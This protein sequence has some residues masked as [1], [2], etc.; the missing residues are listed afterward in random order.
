MFNNFVVTGQY[1]WTP[2]SKTLFDVN[3]MNQDTQ[4]VN[5]DGEENLEEGS[6][7]SVEDIISNYADDVC[8][9][10]TRVNMGNNST[11]NSNG[12]RKAREQYGG[13]S[14]KKNKKPYGFG[15]QLL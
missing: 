3:A 9:L 10:V 1:V 13:Q 15:A 8:K 12:K 11:T 6:G 14:R 7:D 2:S 5:V 4:D